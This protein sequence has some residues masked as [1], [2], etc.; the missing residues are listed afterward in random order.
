MSQSSMSNKPSPM[1]KSSSSPKGKLRFGARVKNMAVTFEIR[2]FSF[3]PFGVECFDYSK[4]NGHQRAEGYTIPFRRCMESESTED[5]IPALIDAGFFA[6]SFQRENIFVDDRKHGNDNWPRY[7]M[8]REVP[9]G[10][11]S[12]VETR[13]EGMEILKSFFMDPRN[14]S[15]PPKSIECMDHT[16]ERPSAMQHFF[17]DRDVLR[18]LARII[19][20]EY[21]NPLFSSRFPE[22][23]LVAFPGPTY[24]AEAV[25]GL[26]FGTPNPRNHDRGAYA[27]NYVP[28]EQNNAP[29]I[30]NGNHPRGDGNV[31]GNGSRLHDHGETSDSD[32]DEDK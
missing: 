28:N 15:Y 9:G 21:H 32:S 17:L 20:D 6:A 14:T 27:P 24:P 12:S 5:N 16:S 7:W 26:G 4:V 23:A 13:R 10:N 22:H 3:P 2:A 18:I 19:D 29:P 25:V 1:R 8:I 31:Q 11:Q 30:V